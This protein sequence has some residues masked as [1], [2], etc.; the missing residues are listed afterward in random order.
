MKLN[1]VRLLAVFAVALGLLLPCPATGDSGL[2][3]KL[4]Q[5]EARMRA[6][7]R[8]IKEHQN[9][10]KQIGE[11]EQGVIS[12]IE[13]LDQKKNLTEQRIRV[14][15]LR[16]EKAKKTVEELNAEIQATECE[17]DSMRSVLEGRLL[18]IYKYGGIAEFNLLLSASTAH[19]AME[20][21]LLL[22]R[23]AQQDELMITDML[24]KKERL[25][26]A[27]V[28]LEEERRQ[29]AAN[30]AALEQSRMTYRKEIAESNAFLQKVRSERDLHQKAVKELQDSQR[31]IQA[32]IMDLMK[33]KREK[34]MLPGKPEPPTRREEL[35]S[36]GKLA[37]PLPSRGEIVSKFGMRVHPTFKTRIMHTGIDI[38]MANGTPVYSAGPGEV[39]YAGWLRGYGQIV[40]IDHG[41]SLSSV[42]AHL[43]RLDVGEG[44]R[45]KTGQTIGV[46]GM[47]GTTTGAH[48]HFEVRVNGE[49]K[50]PMQYLGK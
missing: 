19:E 33:K 5:E 4:V 49:A 18:N 43:G 21:T 1:K 23:I 28:Q 7:E 24:S 30:A 3:S 48:L 41:R 16:N 46:V 27:V 12:R 13:D 34:E 36:G 42:Y 15:E 11:R 26:E 6:L 35:P 31:E 2:D 25:G 47:T 29:L 44:D 8:Q 40:I 37:W 14:L 9:R 38:R 17:L 45:V 32:T 20:T 22:N 39:L 10:V 50:D